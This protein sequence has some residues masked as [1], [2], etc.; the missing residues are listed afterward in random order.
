[1]FTLL[2]HELAC[3]R[4]SPKREELSSCDEFT[5]SFVYLRHFGIYMCTWEYFYYKKKTYMSRR[6]SVKPGAVL[7]KDFP[8][9]LQRLSSFLGGYLVVE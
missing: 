3:D 2:N 9:G 8:S 4:G 6:D 1:M 7:D 5:F